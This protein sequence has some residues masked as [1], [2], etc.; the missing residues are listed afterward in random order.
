METQFVILLNS[1]KELSTTFGGDMSFLTRGR[2]WPDRYVIKIGQIFCENLWK[3]FE[4]NFP[5]SL[6]T[7]CV[8]IYN[9]RPTKN[10][11]TA[12]RLTY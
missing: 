9:K 4:Q 11:W 8:R 6:D 7:N 5:K 2:I 3:L 12:T 10:Q 1:M